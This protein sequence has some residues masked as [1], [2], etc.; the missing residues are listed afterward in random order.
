MSFADGSWLSKAIDKTVGEVWGDVDEEV[1]ASHERIGD[2]G[3]CAKSAGSRFWLFEGLP[4]SFELQEVI[5]HF[6]I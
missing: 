3:K 6:N 4:S 5:I 1:V 2:H